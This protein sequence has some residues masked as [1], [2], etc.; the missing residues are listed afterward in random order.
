[1]GR[2]SFDK[3]G[4][5]VAIDNKEVEPK[6]QKKRFETQGSFDSPYQEDHH[7]RKQ[8][9]KEKLLTSKDLT[10]LEESPAQDSPSSYDNNVPQNKSINEHTSTDILHNNTGDSLYWSLYE[11][12]KKLEPLKYSNGKTQ[13][14]IVKEVSELIEK[15]KKVIFIHGVCG[16]GKS[17]IALNIGRLLGRAT[18]VVPVKNLQKQYQD[19]YSEKKYLLKPSGSKMKIAVITGRDNHDSIIEPGISC[20]DPNLPDTIIITEK[21]RAQILKY[22]KENPFIDN[23]IIPPLTK[24]KRISIAPSNPYWSPIIASDYELNQLKDAKKKKY[25]GVSGK[26]YI[27]YHRK[28]GCSYYD[29][30]QAYIDSDVLIFNAAKYEIEMAIGR[31]PETDVDIIDE[32][33]A[34]LDNFSREDSI[35]L[36]RLANS[37]KTIYPYMEKTVAD[38]EALQELVASEIKNKT[39]LGIDEKAIFSLKDTITGKII[40]LLL[41]SRDLQAEIALDEAHYAND[42]L[43]TA[44]DF[45]DLFEDTYATYNKEDNDIYVNLVTTNVAKR[46]ADL[47]SKTKVL[48]LMSGTLHSPAVLSNVFGIKDFAI[49]EAEGTTPGEIEIHKTGKEMDC[50]YS[51]LQGK[52]KEYLQSLSACL[53]K[54]KK[55]VLIHVNAYSDLPTESEKSEYQIKNLISKE[56]LLAIQGEDKNGELISQ[57]KNKQS[58]TLFS[59]KCSRGVDFPGDICNSII[60]TKYPNPNTQD[61]FWK[62]LEKTH[63]KYFWQIYQDKAYREFLQRL[64]RALRSKHDHVFVLSPDSRVLDALKKIQ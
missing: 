36:S 10:F 30:F 20:A 58:D 61:I 38:L 17:S 64:Y 39:S 55:P 57:F 13:E 60:F 25:Y 8:K 12:T 31:K 40:K 22:Y 44:F 51:S 33:D 2:I 59:T 19:D 21:N 1:M 52:R 6:P 49:V 26:E 7:Y 18:I 54:A 15:G 23:K 43:E 42:V 9:A 37:L 4:R 53:E 62:I 63:N 16:T 28:H 45:S 50:K 14:D 29:Q 27:F 34:F 3:D 11:D 24:L 46:F 35:N 32:A 48:V 47:I 56:S 5:L 41:R